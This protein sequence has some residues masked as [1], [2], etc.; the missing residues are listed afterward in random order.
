MT[1]NFKQPRSF[2]RTST[3][4]V[5]LTSIA[6]TGLSGCMLAAGAAAGGAA[7]YI[8]GHSAGKDEAHDTIHEHNDDHVVTEERTVRYREVD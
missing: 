5:L 7:G 2:A 4:L 6:C 8:A 3:L 1:Q